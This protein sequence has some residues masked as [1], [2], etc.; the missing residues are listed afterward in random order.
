MPARTPMMDT[1]IMSSMREK[2]RGE[3]GEGRIPS[4]YRRGAREL[5]RPAR[6]RLVEVIYLDHNA[7]T[8]VLPEVLDAMLPYLRE[9]H[10]NPSSAHALRAFSPTAIEE[11]R[12][13]VAALIHCDADE[14]VFTASGTEASNIAIRGV[15]DEEPPDTACIVTTTIEHPATLAP[16]AY[17]AK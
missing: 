5:K 17:L 9:H 1:A 14:V 12:E 3:R 16:C 15:C 8:P 13:Q 4:L 11:A 2:P 6:C 7:S 10:G